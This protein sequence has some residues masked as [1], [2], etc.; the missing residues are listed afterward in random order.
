LL[1]CLKVV[2]WGCFLHIK[3]VL[4]VAFMYKSGAFGVIFGLAG[5][6]TDC[7]NDTVTL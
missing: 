5:L 6:L 4:L 1:L 2:L 7:Q 3:V